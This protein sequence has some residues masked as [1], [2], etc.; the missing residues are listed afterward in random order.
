MAELGF[1][2]FLIG[3]P[4]DNPEELTELLKVK[5]TRMKHI[6]DTISEKNKKES[7]YTVWMYSSPYVI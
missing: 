2:F 5:P 3:D 7:P 1:D 4:W 6:G